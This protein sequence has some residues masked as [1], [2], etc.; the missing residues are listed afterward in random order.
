[1]GLHR[2][3]AW[4]TKARKTRKTPKAPKFTAPITA[5]AAEAGED[6]IRPVTMMQRKVLSLVSGVPHGADK[7]LNVVQCEVAYARR[8][9]SG[10]DRACDKIDLLATTAFRSTAVGAV[11]LSCLSI[12]STRIAL[13]VTKLCRLGRPEQG[14]QFPRAGVADALDWY[15]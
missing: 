9:A 5:G 10:G 6:E 13:A 4:S 2:L 7:T 8:F 3:A 12:L 11:V 14:A 15:A 1:M